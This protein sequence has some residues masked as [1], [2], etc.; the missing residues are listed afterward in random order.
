MEIIQNFLNKNFFEDLKKLVLESEFAWFQRKNMVSHSNDD[1]GYFT[2]SFYAEP[3]Q[4]KSILTTTFFNNYEFCSS[5]ELENI[6]A[7]QFHPEKSG[8]TG[9]NL[10]QNFFLGE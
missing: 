5:I 7:C 10:L 8:S 9:L 6:F 3:E 1:L 4:K 2:H